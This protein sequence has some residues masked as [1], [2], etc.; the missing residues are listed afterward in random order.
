MCVFVFA[1]MFFKTNSR[2]YQPTTLY[3]WAAP[4]NP[5]RTATIGLFEGSWPMRILSSPKKM[6]V[7]F[8]SHGP[9]ALWPYGKQKVYLHEKPGV[10]TYIHTYV[11]INSYINTVIFNCKSQE[12]SLTH[13]KKHP[14]LF[15][16][17]QLEIS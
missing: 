6:K 4:R 8:K 17:V 7:P 12:P 10:T 14:A 1:N 15:F 16:C 3:I 5:P 13:F 11:Y 9:M 2:R